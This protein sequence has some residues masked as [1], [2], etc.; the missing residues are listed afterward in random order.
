[1]EDPDVD[2]RIILQWIFERLDGGGIDWI[3]TGDKTVW[4]DNENR[5]L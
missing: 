1:L 4:T 2:G 3:C 5:I